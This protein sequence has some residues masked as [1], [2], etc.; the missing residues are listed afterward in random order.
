MVLPFLLASWILVNIENGLVPD[1][2]KTLFE[3]LQTY[4]R[5]SGT[6]TTKICLKIWYKKL[7]PH[8]LGANELTSIPATSWNDV[9]GLVQ[10]CSISIAIELQIPQHCTEPSM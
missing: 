8:V 2:T 1:N 6:F 5:N 3:P 7:Q 9:N 10:L 4:P